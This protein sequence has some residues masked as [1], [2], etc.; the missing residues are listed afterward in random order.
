MW[1]VLPFKELGAAAAE[2]GAFGTQ[3]NTPPPT[4]SGTPAA[5]SWAGRG[6][7]QRPSGRGGDAPSVGDTIPGTSG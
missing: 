5:G 3:G 2:W 4:G 6:A 1:Y 7:A